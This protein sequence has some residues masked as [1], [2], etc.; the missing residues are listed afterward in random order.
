MVETDMNSPSQFGKVPIQIS[1]KEFDV[2]AED[3]LVFIR[4]V[5]LGAM[6]FQVFSA[7]H[8]DR[9]LKLGTAQGKIERDHEQKPR[10]P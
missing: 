3:P 4:E 7:E 9:P 5:A 6:S 2:A 1:E 8:P 10:F